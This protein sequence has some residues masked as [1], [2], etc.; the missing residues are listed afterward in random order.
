MSTVLIVGGSRGFGRGITQAFA[1]RGHAITV[2]ARD[3]GALNETVQEA[4]R[5]GEF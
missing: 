2:V 4:E 1:K 5:A 3:Q